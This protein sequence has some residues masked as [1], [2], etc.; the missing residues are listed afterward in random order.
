MAR[1]GEIV[2]SAYTGVPSFHGIGWTEIDVRGSES[3]EESNR[4]RTFAKDVVISED[5]RNELGFPCQTH[6]R[7]VHPKRFGRFVNS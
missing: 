5:L 4:I 2:Q 1:A 7:V 6:A 3:C